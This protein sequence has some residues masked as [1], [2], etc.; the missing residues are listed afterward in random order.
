MIF[1][2]TALIARAA[3]LEYPLERVKQQP[4]SSEQSATADLVLANRML[5][6][7]EAAVFDVSG[8]ISIRSTSNPQHFLIARDIAPGMVTASDIIEDDLAGQ[9]VSADA[10]RQHEDRLIHAAIYKARPDISSIVLTRAPVIVAFSA[11]TAQLFRGDDVV[12]V[13]DA[14]HTTGG[15]RVA[16]RGRAVADALGARS[17]LM[18][19]NDGAV[20]VGRTI[21]NV[22]ADA[23]ALR[24]AAETQERLIEMGK[25]WTGDPLK[26]AANAPAAPPQPLVLSRT[27]GGFGGI[28][29]TWDY[30]KQIVSSSLTARDAAPNSASKSASG[31][32]MEEQTIDDLIAANRIISYRVLGLADALGHI[33]VRS[34][35]NPA[36]YYISRNVSAGFVTGADII[37][38]DLDSSAVAGPRTDEFQ[39]SYIHGEIY[40]ARPDVVAVLHAHTPEIRTFS[41]GLV[42]LRPVIDA[43][44]FVGDGLP[45]HDIRQFDPREVLIRTPALG[46]S[47]AAA[48]GHRPG[49]L[50]KGHGFALTGSSLAD[51]IQKAYDLRKNAQIQQQAIALRGDVTYF[52][53]GQALDLPAGTQAWDYWKELAASR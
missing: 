30:Y 46:R 49:V 1:A 6:S 26:A 12:P 5:A 2:A 44:A 20:V 45:I 15:A 43:V 29:R 8:D 50:L 19:A 16:A 3:P 4:Q 52:R 42:A 18:L 22:V 31:A 23:I 11:S 38:N 47:L 48:L 40:K 37:E 41:L 53:P 14:H 28:E 10:R 36:H 13:V 34:P 51:V 7:A 9:P 25:H 21:Y 27:G 32:A 24:S 35:R 33:S 17:A 39:E